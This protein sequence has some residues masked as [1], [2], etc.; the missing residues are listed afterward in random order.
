ML[1]IFFYEGHSC[2]VPG[3]RSVLVMDGNMK[4]ARQVCM[5]KSIGELHFPGTCG[6]IIVG[7]W[8]VNCKL[9]NH[10]VIT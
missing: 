5:V 3:C 6:S 7:K 4:N 2:D 8:H 10:F 9:S 1:N